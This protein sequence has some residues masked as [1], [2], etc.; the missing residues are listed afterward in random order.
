[1]IS[2]HFLLTPMLN[3]TLEYFFDIS[4]ASGDLGG[5]LLSADI[6]IMEVYGA[7]GRKVHKSP[8]KTCQYSS[9]LLVQ[10]IPS[11]LSG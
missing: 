6:Q 4:N 9:I 10:C 11:V 2:L 3:N 1:M 8:Q 5:F 7:R